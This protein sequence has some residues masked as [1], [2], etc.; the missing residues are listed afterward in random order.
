M[1]AY[2]TGAAVGGAQDATS[3]ETG[4]FS[5]GGSDR[6]LFGASVAGALFGGAIDTTAFKYGGSS[7]TN[8]TQIGTDLTNT[9]AIDL[10]AWGIGP[11]PTGA[12]TAYASFSTAAPSSAI[13]AV[14]YTGVGSIGTP[15]SNTGSDGT[16]SVTQIDMQ[17]TVPGCTAGQTVVAAFAGASTGVN[18]TGFTGQ[19]GTTLRQSAIAALAINGIAICEKVAPANGDVTLNCRMTIAATGSTLYYAV[20]GVQ[21]NDAAVG[22]PLPPPYDLDQLGRRQ[23]VRDMM[24]AGRMAYHDMLDVRAWV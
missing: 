16:N 22:A 13:A 21:L 3:A 23:T 4:S 8:L 15:A 19:S 12:T 9:D 1:S 17:V 5:P 14:S 18:V 20:W 11:G 2:D 6:Y 24:E 7:G 10:T